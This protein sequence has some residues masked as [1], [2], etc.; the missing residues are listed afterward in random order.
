MR[1]EH[2]HLGVEF[3]F[4]FGKLDLGLGLDLQMDRIVLRLLLRL[5]LMRGD[6]LIRLR[7]R[8]RDQ[9]LRI[10]RRR[11][12]GRWRIQKLLSLRLIAV[13]SL[14]NWSGFLWPMIRVSSAA[15]L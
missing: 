7:I 5:R 6:R 12:R 13:G 14:K 9:Q 2:R 1:V 10:G 8:L 4:D 11:W 15:V 3:G